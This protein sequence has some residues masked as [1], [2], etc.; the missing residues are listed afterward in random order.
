MKLFLIEFFTQHY[1]SVSLK[2][3]RLYVEVITWLLYCRKT[4]DDQVIQCLNHHELD[5][6]LIEPDQSMST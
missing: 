3:H 4:D 5:E 2:I 6:S 1:S